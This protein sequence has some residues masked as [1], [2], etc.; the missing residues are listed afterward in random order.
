MDLSYKW[1]KEDSRRSSSY[2]PALGLIKKGNKLG[3]LGE[4]LSLT[5]CHTT[6]RGYIAV[7]LLTLFDANSP[8]MKIEKYLENDEITALCRTN[9][10]PKAALFQTLETTKMNS[11]QFRPQCLRPLTIFKNYNRVLK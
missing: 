10:P 4:A 5:K 9:I 7:V 8:L 3:E 11:K 2:P 1:K 6:L